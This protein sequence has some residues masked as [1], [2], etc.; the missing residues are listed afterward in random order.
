[1]QQITLSSTH[2]LVH[3][4]GQSCT[5]CAAALRGFTLYPKH[6]AETISFIA[7]VHNG[8]PVSKYE[9]AS[10][11]KK[12]R[13]LDYIVYQVQNTFLK[14]EG[15][16]KRGCHKYQNKH[17]IKNKKI[18]TNDPLSTIN[19]YTNEQ[20]IES[21]QCTNSGNKYM[22]SPNFLQKKIEIEK[23]S[24][25]I[26]SNF[27]FRTKETKPFDKMNKS[28]IIPSNIE[29]T[30]AD[31]HLSALNKNLTRSEDKQE[32]TNPAHQP[33]TLPCKHLS[34]LCDLVNSARQ[35]KEL[36]DVNYY[37]RRNIQPPFAVLHKLCAWA[38]KSSQVG[39]I[40]KLQEFTRK[41][42]PEEYVLHLGFKYYLAS[43]M[44]YEGDVEGSLEEL[45]QL[46]LHHPQGHKKIRDT[47]TFI[48][49]QVLRS[50]NEEHE[51]LVLKFVNNVGVE[52]RQLGPALSLWSVG[53]SSS[54]YR[55]QVI[56]E[57][58]LER[59]PGLVNMLW[60]KLDGMV[61]RA[62]WDGDEELLYRILQL[63]LRFQLSEYYAITASALLKLQCDTGNLRGADETIKFAQHMEVR[64][65]PSALQRF[66][67]LLNYHKRPAPLS[68]L[69]LKY[70]PPPL[71]PSSMISQSI[72]I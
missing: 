50:N 51:Q 22:K 15:R 44:C 5:C 14:T 20:I 31:L 67:A 11:L 35:I 1:M 34:L 66:L 42:Y 28:V 3:W 48:I 38:S 9:E 69:A 72:Y 41:S 13:N 52:A 39:V 65:T 63:M 6:F 33:R 4:W 58:L 43:A 47:T 56:S 21:D 45:F 57:E 46:Y 61:Q 7:N 8:K 2:L 23:I 53:F 68:L 30:T 32:A 40:H 10:Q 29:D 70:A 64:L 71:K 37:V 24:M 25:Q 54:H 27:L 17:I 19:K 60:R 49:Y 36:E 59:H 16:R 12:E 26:E 55:H 62:A 18:L